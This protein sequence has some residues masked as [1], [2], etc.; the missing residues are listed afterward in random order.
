M[1]KVNGPK[2]KSPREDSFIYIGADHAGF[3]LKE[4]IKIYLSKTGYTPVDIGNEKYIP[5]D[6]YP[7]YAVKVA[8]KVSETG[9]RGIIICDSG[10]GVCIAANKIKNIR[11]VN[12][13]NT[14]VARMSREH[15]NTNILCLG[16]NYIK[17][18]LAKKI[19]NIWLETEFSQEKRHHRR[20]DKINRI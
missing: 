9:G 4:Y 12:P 2:N 17:P 14:V 5:G 1:T 11:A 7:D 19:I 15:N 13:T 8:R 10:V 3:R 18:L 16:Q 6:D 20:V